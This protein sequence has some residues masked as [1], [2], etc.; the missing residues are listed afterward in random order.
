MEE[1]SKIKVVHLVFD[2]RYNRLM[3]RLFVV[4]ALVAVLSAVPLFGQMRGGRVGASFGRGF[5]SH[6]FGSVRGGFGVSRG[7]FGRGGSFGFN[8]GGFGFSRGGRFFPGRGRFIGHG[9]FFGRSPIF[10]GGS[11]YWGPDYYD[12]YYAYPYA[13][14]A[15]IEP[16]PPT[17]YSPDQY[18]ERSDLRRDIDELNGKIDHLQRDVERGVPRPPVR[19]EAVRQST[20]LVFKDKH[21]EEVQNY[22]V[23]GGTLWILD[24]KNANKVPLEDLDLDATARLNDERGVEFEIPK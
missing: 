2:R 18:D 3:R 16:A 12:P 19:Q 13:Y 21:K 4:A 10:L 9:A 14:S 17:Y 22:A 1:E 6:N 15:P 8:R 20:M 24:E 11:F 7:S 5:S 23:V